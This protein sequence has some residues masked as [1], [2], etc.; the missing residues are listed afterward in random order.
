MHLFSHI[1]ITRFNVKMEHWPSEKQLSKPERE[2]WMK[3]RWELFETYCL[4][5]ILQQNTHNFKWLIYFDIETNE[6][7]KKKIRLLE[8]EYDFIIPLFVSNHK[9]FKLQLESDILRQC[10]PEHTH[11]ITTRIDNDDCFHRNAMARIQNCFRG[12]DYAVFNFMKG[13]C[14]QVTPVHLLSDYEYPSGPFLSMIEK[15]DSNRAMELVFSKDHYD[16]IEDENLN[17]I[18]DTHYWIQIIHNNN[19]YNRLLGVPIKNVT[20]LSDFG[21]D[22]TT[23]N[24]N[25]LA[26]YQKSLK[27]L[28]IVFPFQQVKLFLKQIAGQ[29]IYFWLLRT[30]LGNALRK[31]N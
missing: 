3:N 4:K 7:M 5:S 1:L 19:V 27:Y 6:E 14:L 29:K 31:L 28:F 18:A 12:Q 8:K 21:V 30:P 9:T 16:F 23:I 13:Y 24:I 20:I 22:E 17:Q 10:C 11:V 25:L 15:I 2:S 26:F